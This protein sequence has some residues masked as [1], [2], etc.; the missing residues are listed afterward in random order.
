MAKSL[1]TVSPLIP[2]MH[3]FRFQFQ[4]TL[5]GKNLSQVFFSFG[6]APENVQQD[7]IQLL[8]LKYKETQNKKW[9]AWSFAQG[10]QD[11]GVGKD[12]WVQMVE[13][14][15]DKMKRCFWGQF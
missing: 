13:T 7:E 6:L 5:L 15:R 4:K 11:Y 2:L 9:E 1:L 12:L 8:G 14:Q 10:G 3:K